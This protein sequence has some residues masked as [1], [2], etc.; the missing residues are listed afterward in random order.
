ME[1]T[2]QIEVWIASHFH[3]QQR[4]EWAKEMLLSLSNQTD[5][6]FNIKMSWSKEKYINENLNDIATFLLRDK[7]TLFYHETRKTQFEHIKHIFDNT[8]PDSNVIIL[9]CDDD[10]MYHKTRIENIRNVVVQYSET[11]FFRDHCISICGE[12]KFQKYSGEIEWKLKS[13]NF[14]FELKSQAGKIDSYQDFANNICYFSLITK[15]FNEA[16]DTK[17]VEKNPNIQGLL[18]CAFSGW[19]TQNYK[20]E[21]TII[22]KVLYL[23]RVERCFPSRAMSWD[24][25]KDFNFEEVADEWKLK[26]IFFSMTDITLQK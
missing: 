10:D 24:K 19:L 22:N 7:I 18:D 14:K 26:N 5:K 8:L 12:D 25:E 16:L 9:F 2:I 4:F 11:K 3:S 6:N 17:Y 21:N 23:K 13:S 15:F 20:T 1:N